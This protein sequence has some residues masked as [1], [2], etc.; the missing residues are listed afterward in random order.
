MRVVEGILHRDLCDINTVTTTKLDQFRLNRQK[1]LGATMPLRQLAFREQQ[2]H[3]RRRIEYANSAILGQGDQFLFKLVF[4]QC[5]V[6]PGHDRINLDLLGNQPQIANWQSRDADESGLA[7]LLHF[8][9]SR[10]RFID[11]LLAI[12]EFD[13]VNLV[14][15][16]IIG[17]QPSQ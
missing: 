6:P 5:V 17:P 13:V 15:I 16:D 4:H 1:R 2:L 8:T 10:Q 3:Q 12:S 11:D 7:A 9:G 14:D